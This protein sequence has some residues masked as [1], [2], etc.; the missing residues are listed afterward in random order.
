MIITEQLEDRLKRGGKEEIPG[1]FWPA[2]RGSGI[3]LILISL[4]PRRG[5]G[6]SIRLQILLSSRLG[7]CQVAEKIRF[8]GIDVG[9]SRGLPPSFPRFF[10]RM[11]A[12]RSAT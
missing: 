4:S 1:D 12:L 10:D 3:S 7:D 8:I 9:S 6:K 5:R 11:H 2:P